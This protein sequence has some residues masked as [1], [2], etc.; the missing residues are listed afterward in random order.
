[1][2]QPLKDLVDR[3]VVE[4][5]ADRLA[6]VAPG[7]DRR[8]FVADLDAV[9]PGL[10][11]KARIE[12]IARRI[13]A[14]LDPGYRT[15]L[16]AVVRVA[17]DEPA[18]EGFAAW[19]LCT[20][21]EVFGVDDPA[22]SLPAMEH[23]T[24]RASCEFAIRPFLE[25]H[26]EAAYHQLEAFTG[27]DDEA[28]RRLASEGTRPRLPWGRRVQRLL[29]D[30]G[31]GLELLERLRR[32]PSE[33]VRR[34]VANHLNDVAKDHP[35]LVVATAGRWAAA[36]PPVDRRM[37][38]HAL[39]TLVKRGDRQAL[40]VLGFTT[41]PRVAVDGFEVEPVEVVV[42]ERVT[43]LADLRSVATA[44]QRLVVD[45]VVHHVTASGGTSPTVLKWTTA[46]LAAGGNLHLR[47]RRLIAD[48]STRTYQ[49]GRHRVELQVGGSVLDETSF[50]VRR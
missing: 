47:K 34:S 32:D 26:F 46:D 23:L 19:P 3:G 1:M 45:L 43:F 22:A 2:A 24:Q 41:R 40:E 29:D 39:R 50:E 33:V 11:L 15:A 16:A 28:V 21:V 49:S 38:A 37:L 48:G 42:G 4:G 30:P 18:V 35:G 9:L 5:L 13:A 31:P 8:S 25:R 12:A 44:S 36:N 6:R 7:F 20:F 14:G 10:E 17:R 27:H